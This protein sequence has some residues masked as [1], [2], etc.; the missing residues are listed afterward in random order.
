MNSYCKREDRWT[1]NLSE[2]KVKCKT[3][4]SGGQKYNVIC[5]CGYL[6]TVYEKNGCI[7]LTLF[8]PDWDFD[9]N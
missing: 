8:N 9:N 4:K 6:T 5:K 1:T 7:L 2:N 3:N